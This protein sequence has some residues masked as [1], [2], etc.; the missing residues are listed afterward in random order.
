MS[1]FYYLILFTIIISIL[2][3]IY[4]VIYNKIQNQILKLKETESEIDETLRQKYDLIVKIIEIIND[5]ELKKISELK[6]KDFSSFEFIRKLNEY[7][8]KA[9]KIRND[10]KKLLKNEELNNN[11]NE[12]NEINT[13]LTAQIRY[14]NDNTSIYNKLFVSFPS[15]IIAK[16]SKL[17]ERM[18]F[19]GKNLSDDIEKDFKL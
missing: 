11:F 6:E 1:T 8:T 18:Y 10:N 16:I 3:V 17:E 15:N 9:S 12:V 13:K 2:L 7:E 14:Y 4:V 5:K 19:D